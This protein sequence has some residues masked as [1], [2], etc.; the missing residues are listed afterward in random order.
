V[1]VNTDVY[2]HCGYTY[3]HTYIHTHF[4][5]EQRYIY[6]ELNR[7]QTKEDVDVPGSGT[8]VTGMGIKMLYV[9]P[10]KFSKS[11]A[12][13]SILSKLEQK[14]LLSRF[15]IDEAHCVSQWG[16]DFRPGT[17]VLY[18]LHMYFVCI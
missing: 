7:Y 4:V 1:F 9:T 13:K 17:C 12:L 16:H 14:G 3:I 8:D 5:G 10:E 15:V 2:K 11:D 6:Q 18:V